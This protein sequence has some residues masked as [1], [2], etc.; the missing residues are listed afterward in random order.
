[1]NE[2][3]TSHDNGYIAIA[4]N[5]L[6]Q[7]KLLT[8]DIASVKDIVTS[9]SEDIKELKNTSEITTNQKNIIKDK[10]S[11]IVRRD[12]VNPNRSRRSIAYAKVY[13][14]LRIYGLSSP[15]ERTEKQHFK[16]VNEALDNYKLDMEYVN[17]REEEIKKENE[18]DQ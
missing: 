14:D 6:M 5:L 10:I 1:M 18:E 7:T 9:Q 15:Y 16:A 3:Q 8:N 11:Y 12:L 2:L 4:E 17:K 13:R